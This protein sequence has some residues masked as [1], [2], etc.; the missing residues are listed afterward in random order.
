MG[1]VLHEDQG[2][3]FSKTKHLIVIKNQTFLVS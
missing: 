1:E 3:L 2:F